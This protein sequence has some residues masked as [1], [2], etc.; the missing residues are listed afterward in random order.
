MQKFAMAFLK[1]LREP[2]VG[3]I[4]VAIAAIVVAGMSVY[5]MT[6]ALKMMGW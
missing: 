2:G 3:V 1:T 5:G 4:I 6:L